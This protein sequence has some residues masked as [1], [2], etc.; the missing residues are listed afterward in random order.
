MTSRIS[1]INEILSTFKNPSYLEIGYGSGYCFE[2]INTHDKICCDPSPRISDK[3]NN[4]KNCI[5][6]SSDEFFAANEKKFDV[7]FI[8]GH[9]EYDYVKK[10]FSNAMNALKEGGYVIL[11]DCNPP[12]RME[13]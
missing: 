1:L 11:H 2:N 13:M 6:L 9:H 4:N 8:D 3:F 12:K 5:L 7:I 10:D